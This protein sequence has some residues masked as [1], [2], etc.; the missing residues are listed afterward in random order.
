MKHQSKW[1]S[2]GILFLSTLLLLSSLFRAADHALLQEL[3]VSGASELA[4]VIILDAGHGG[5][6]GGASGVNGVLEK[7]LNLALTK[8]LA[9]L[10][11]LAGYTVIETRTDDRLLYSENTPKGHKKQS[12]LSNRLAFT[13]SYPDSVFISIHMNTFPND[14]CEGVQVWYSQNHAQSIDWAN[15]IQSKVKSILQPQNNRKVKAASSNI[16]LLRHAKTPAILI[17]CGFLS[18]PAECEKLC[19]PFYRQQLIAVFLAAITEKSPL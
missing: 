8:E 18:T 16:Y 4:P 11:R 6:D 9:A 2:F 19:E 10:L 3:A 7:D 14:S 5:E 13:E 1:I 17:E 12:D 15:A